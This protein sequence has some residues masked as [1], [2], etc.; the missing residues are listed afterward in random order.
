M[1][2]EFLGMGTLFAFFLISQYLTQV[3]QEVI[4]STS[5]SRLTI[6]PP[7]DAVILTSLVLLISHLNNPPPG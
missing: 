2:L 7:N 3:M 5:L 6:E 1:S 4:V